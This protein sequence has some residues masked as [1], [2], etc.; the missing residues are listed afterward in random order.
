MLCKYCA[1]DI[2][3]EQ[4]KKYF[5]RCPECYNTYKQKK[6][7]QSLASGFLFFTIGLLYVIMF[8]N[9]GWLRMAM[10][11]QYLML[12]ILGMFVGTIWFQVAWRWA[13]TD[14]L[15][16]RY[17]KKQS[18]MMLAVVLPITT[19]LCLITLLFTNM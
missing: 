6:S 10:R 18:L 13:F 1:A 15:P 11:M 17:D 12:G 4:D 19:M 14:V 7:K 3:T 2:S 16:W 9:F 8:Y 5:G